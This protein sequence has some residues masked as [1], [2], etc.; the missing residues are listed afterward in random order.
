MKNVEVVHSRTGVWRV[1]IQGIPPLSGWAVQYVSGMGPEIKE[2]Y[3]LSQWSV[4]AARDAATFNFEPGLEMCFN[5]ESD[6]NAIS[7]VLR[8]M[9]EIET[10]VVKV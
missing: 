10:R 8:K 9:A 4:N 1:P 7:A 2:G 5:D 6:A 3:W